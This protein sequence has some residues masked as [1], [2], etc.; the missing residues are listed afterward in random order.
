[1]GSILLVVVAVGVASKHAKPWTESSTTTAATMW[2][3]DNAT[4]L[5]DVFAAVA[6][7]I[8]AIV[9]VFVVVCKPQ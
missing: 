6:A 8:L 9:I 1:L 2:I 3:Y 7:T 5:D 4:T